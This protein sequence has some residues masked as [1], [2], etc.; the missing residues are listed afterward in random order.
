VFL[1][2][3]LPLLFGISV[4]IT[5]PRI[6]SINFSSGSNASGVNE[7]LRLASLR[8]TELAVVPAVL[9]ERGFTGEL[10]LRV[11]AGHS[12]VYF[13]CCCW[14]RL[15]V[16]SLRLFSFIASSSFTSKSANQQRSKRFLTQHFRKLKKKSEIVCAKH[17]QHHPERIAPRTTL[18]NSRKTSFFYHFLVE[19]LATGRQAPACLQAGG[20]SHGCTCFVDL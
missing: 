5:P 11:G 10:T 8:V 3:L 13:V 15:W 7:V 6:V 19:R 16:L 14:C 9:E 18:N 4:T 12:A 2:Q 1:D 17:L 20:Q